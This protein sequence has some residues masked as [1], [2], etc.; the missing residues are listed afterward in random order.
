MIHLL[1]HRGPRYLAVTAFCFAFNNFLLIALSW[2]AVHYA[3]CAL[4][5]MTVMIPLS[6]LLHARFTFQQA[7]ERATFVRFAVVQALNIPVA[8]MFF[9][10]LSGRLS[11]PMT[12]AAPLTTT[13][14]FTWNCVS[15]WWAMKP[16]GRIS[17]SVSGRST[18]A[19]MADG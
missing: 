18:E 7:G 19:P 15:A 5:S 17:G 9:Y 16:S 11:L 3:W 2:Q 10:V 8:L 14:M 1:L 12:I 13:V 4:I 6:Y